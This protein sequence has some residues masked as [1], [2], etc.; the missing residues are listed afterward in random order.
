MTESDTTTDPPA[1]WVVL[2]PVRRNVIRHTI[3]NPVWANMFPA[4]HALERPYAEWTNETFN[5]LAA[6]TPMFSAIKAARDER[7]DSS[8]TREYQLDHP[9]QQAKDLNVVL[10]FLQARITGAVAH[11]YY[12]RQALPDMITLINEM[13]IDSKRLLGETARQPDTRPPAD[14]N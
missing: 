4:I 14:Y 6:N 7:L 12:A 1:Y 3:F 2:N 9:H 5:K 8:P 10:R 11:G 13:I